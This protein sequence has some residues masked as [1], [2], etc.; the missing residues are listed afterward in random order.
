M[1]IQARLGGHWDV[2]HEERHEALG[3]GY[4]IKWKADARKYRL[5]RFKLAFIG[6]TTKIH[7]PPLTRC[8]GVGTAITHNGTGSVKDLNGAVNTD[9][10]IHGRSTGWVEGYY[11]PRFRQNQPGW[12]MCCHSMITVDNDWDDASGAYISWDGRYLFQKTTLAADDWDFEFGWRSAGG[13]VGAV[14]ITVEGLRT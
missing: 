6:Q 4:L 9:V 2:V 8:Y 1:T 11:I 12:L 10:H 5:L 7:L 3:S 14:S 13:E